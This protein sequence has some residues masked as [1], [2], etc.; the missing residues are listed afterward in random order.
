MRQKILTAISLVLVLVLSLFIY[1]YKLNEIPNGFYVDE[2]SVAYNAYSI[3]TTG[4]DEFGQSYPILF[5]LFGS[6][7]PP[8]FIY[9]SAILVPFWG[10]EPYTF[11]L[12]SALSALVSIV[13]FILFTKK[14]E[15]YKLSISYTIATL[16]YAITPW[17]VFNARLG[18]EVTLAYLVFN[19]GIYFLLCAL[20]KPKNLL[21]GL[22]LLSLSIYIAH[23]Q[24][25][26]FIVF[27]FFYFLVFRK[28]IFTRKNFK[29]LF[30]SIFAT[31]LLQIPN[32][33][34]ILTTAFW[35]KTSILTDKTLIQILEN[36]GSQLMT[37][38]SPKSLFYKLPDIDL[39]HILPEMS[40]M[41]NWM[42]VPFLI[43]VYLMIRRVR[44]NNF[45]FLALLFLIS[46]FPAALSGYF[47]S[48]QRALPLLFP[49]A[50]VIGLGLDAIAQRISR[51]I[52]LGI[53]F[54]IITYSLVVLGRS[55]FIL[56]PKEG[57]VA[58]HY[59]YK[60]LAAYI[61]EHGDKHFTFDN[62]RN[63]RSYI[64][65]LYFLRYPPEKYQN[66]VNSSYRN[67]YYQAIPAPD[68]YYFANIEVRKID[69]G[70][71]ECL[72]QIIV[73]DPLAV[74]ELD[75]KDHNL[76]QVE[77]IEDLAGHAIFK[78]YATHPA[79]HCLTN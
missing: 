17:L 67:Q 5:R 42:V 69:W 18:Y 26:L 15:L 38:Y 37:Y 7:T 14:L 21:W 31:V 65:L 12:I 46:V 77:E 75:I 19:I 66:Q 64:E 44:K 20:D 2:A 30:F 50:V 39:Q 41:Y 34:I 8:V 29:I 52:Y 9:L 4:K 27:L 78:L 16:F 53:I 36:V 47:I 68:N 61:T 24:K 74:S 3:F 56:F 58:W 6:Y 1:T 13:V 55:Y 48:I 72:D 40:V 10:M 62:S 54:L 35:S 49:L 59:G 25:F 70:K 22:P 23:T 28:Q 45:K 60:E 32:L 76:T 43:G 63:A 79:K 73:G 51:V 57:A 71:D 11:R 33:T